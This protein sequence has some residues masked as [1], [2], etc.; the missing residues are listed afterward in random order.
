MGPAVQRVRHPEPGRLRRARPLGD[1]CRR[2]RHRYHRDTARRRCADLPALP[3][4]AVQKQKGAA[5]EALHC[6]AREHIGTGPGGQRAQLRGQGDCPPLLLLLV[7]HALVCASLTSWSAYPAKVHCLLFSLLPADCSFGMQCSILPVP[8]PVEYVSTG[9][10]N[11]WEMTW[12]YQPRYFEPLM[13][14]TGRETVAIMV[15]VVQ[16]MVFSLTGRASSHPTPS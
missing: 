11:V 6:P 12:P 7:P 10:W 3:V 9:L 15:L 13:T 14:Q 2:L 16:L 8:R 4:V 1:V 5:T